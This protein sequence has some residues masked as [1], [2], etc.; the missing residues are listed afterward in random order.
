MA[1]KPL[2]SLTFPGLS[3]TYTVPQVDN[4][5]AVSGAAADAKK[6]GDELS[7]LK[8]DLNDVNNYVGLLPIAWEM[9]GMYAATGIE[10]GSSSKVR[11]PFIKVSPNEELVFY[12]T[13]AA[14]A[15]FS[16]YEF[17]ENTETSSGVN[18]RLKFSNVST[19]YPTPYTVG[20][21]TNYI[22]IQLDGTSTDI[23]HELIATSDSMANFMTASAGDLSETDLNNVFGK[24]IWL[25]SD[26]H[27]YTNKP[28]GYTSNVGFLLVAELNAGW[29][30]QL[31]WQ[32]SGGK[33]WKR[34]GKKAPTPTW[35]TWQEISG[36]TNNYTN[37]YSFP[38]YSSS[39]TIEQISPSI[40]T[41]T[42]AYLAPTGDSTDRTAEIVAMLTSL[43]VCRLGKGTYYVNGIDMPNG[44]SIIGAGNATKLLLSGTS[45]GYAI[46]MGQDCTVSDCFIAGSNGIVTLSST[47]GGR[48]GILWQGNYTQTQASSQ[49]PA[50]GFISNVRIGH[51]TGGGI[52]CYDTGYGT[53]NNLE[54]SNV[55][56]TNCGAGINISYF[57][58]FHKF[59]NVRTPTCYYGCVNN[60]GNNTFVNCDFSGCI[61]GFLMDNSTNQSINN[62]HG[63]CIGCVFNHSDSNN[64]IGIKILN[65][66]NGYVFSGCQI[67][68]SQVDIEDSDGVVVSSSNFGSTNC[69]ITISGGGA[70]LFNGNM[71]ETAP[72]ITVTNNDKV[73]FV[74]CYVRSTGAVVQPS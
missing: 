42:N 10:Y 65:C 51:F 68:Y 25:M 52:T 16:V 4:T 41:D 39:Y 14:T 66:D 63:S 34:R 5:L 7:D 13:Y 74:N 27:T 46:K 60:G 69:T 20:N 19:D 70:V 45:D 38:E 67:F 37:E 64:G 29:T 72:T 23:G 50:R 47:I 61:L 40:T 49:Q 22:R 55:F 6:T 3:D 53:Y 11:T 9:G 71:H 58:E 15:Y 32:F 44:T 17:A 31:L 2:K 48:H 56:I 54:V 8:Q 33:M 21:S 73:H 57:S 24:N 26:S 59:T 12:G 1:N 30:I 35:E 62:S 36:T 28:S 18:E 43:G